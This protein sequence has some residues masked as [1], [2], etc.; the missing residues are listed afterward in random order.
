MWNPFGKKADTP[1]QVSEKVQS[2]A[3]AQAE[4]QGSAPAN[5]TPPAADQRKQCIDKCNADYPRK[6]WLG[7]FGGKRKS[8]KSKKA[9][10]TKR[11][12]ASSKK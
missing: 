4:V 3:P 5:T 6:K 8:K 9:R 12:R 1:A 7:V 10:K 11:R 2:T